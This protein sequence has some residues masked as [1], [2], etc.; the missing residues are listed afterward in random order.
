MILIFCLYISGPVRVMVAKVC[1]LILVLGGGLPL[2]KEGP[3]V[4][5]SACI[6]VF[7]LGRQCFLPL[8]T[9]LEQ[10][11]GHI[12][13]AAVS[14]GVG[15]TFSAPV[16]GVLFAIELMMPHVYDIT[17]YWGCFCPPCS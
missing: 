7:F 14:V 9:N 6:S 13:L 12:L 1:G 10:T 8:R 16:G 3:F 11:E 17:A 2:G 4:H 15:A 5:I